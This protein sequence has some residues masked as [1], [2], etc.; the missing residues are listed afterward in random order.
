MSG[1]A[2]LSSEFQAAF[3]TYVRKDGGLVDTRQKAASDM[4]AQVTPG[5]VDLFDLETP[6]LAAIFSKFLG[7]DPKSKAI[8]FGDARVQAFVQSLS[9][10]R[11]EAIA[12]CIEGGFQ[13]PS[14]R[15]YLFQNS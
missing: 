10:E 12:K 11:Q 4:L 1:N 5:Q 15:P 6:D 9:D 3:Q 14:I 13:E 8:T 2:V 7:W